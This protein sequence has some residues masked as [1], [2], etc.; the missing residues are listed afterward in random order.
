MT[1]IMNLEKI[2]EINLNE[3]YIEVEPEFIEVM[4][5]NPIIQEIIKKYIVYLFETFEPNINFSLFEFESN[6]L[7]V[8]DLNY[9]LE[10]LEC[11][12]KDK[13]YNKIIS[14]FLEHDYYKKLSIKRIEEILYMTRC[15]PECDIFIE[16]IVNTLTKI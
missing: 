7:E 1:E 11:G 14:L 5:L 15:N 9:V 13:N 16:N 12:C 8:F 4:E 2:F 3:G 10:T 6:F